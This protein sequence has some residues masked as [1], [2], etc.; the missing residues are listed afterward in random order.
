DSGARAVDDPAARARASDGSFAVARNGT[1]GGSS[2]GDGRTPPFDALIHPG[3]HF[4]AARPTD[5]FSACCVTAS[6]SPAPRGSQPT[7]PRT[8]AQHTAVRRPPLS[9][10]DH[11]RA[12]LGPGGRRRTQAPDRAPDR[13]NARHTA[14]IVRGAGCRPRRDHSRPGRPVLAAPNRSA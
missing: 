14:P 3:S 6:P 5:R 8:R 7:P 1:G 11:S 10:G 9:F 4:G 12:P 2:G 13:G